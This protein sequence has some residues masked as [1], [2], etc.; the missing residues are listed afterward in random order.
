M[1]IEKIIQATNNIKTLLLSIIRKEKNSSEKKKK[2]FNFK[3]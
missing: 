2:C 1:N 3:T